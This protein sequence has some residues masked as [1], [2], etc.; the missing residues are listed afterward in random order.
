MSRPALALAVL[1]VVGACNDPAPP[2]QPTLSDA[3]RKSKYRTVLQFLENPAALD[4]TW[5]RCRNDPGGI[6]D[7]PEC[8]NAGHA[9]ERIM[10]L[11][12]ERA[13]QSLRN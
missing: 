12:R 9:K 10:M 5:A 13:I 3:S 7:T 11:G 8:R 4:E 6:G 1:T 2:A